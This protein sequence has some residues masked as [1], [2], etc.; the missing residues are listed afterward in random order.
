MATDSAWF[1]PLIRR[2]V[3]ESAEM[4]LRLLE[5]DLVDRLALVAERV[6]DSYRRGGKVLLFGNGG[7]ATDA[8]HLATEMCGRFLLER[9]A[10]P[11]LALADNGAALTAIGNDYSFADVFAR[12]I[13]AFG[14][15]GDVAIGISTSGMSDNVIR[16][17]DLARAKGLVT[18]ALTG[19]SGGRLADAAELVI[20]VPATETP[21][22]QEG[23]GLLGHV[24]CEL[25]ERALF[26][27]PASVPL[28]TVFLDRDGTINRKAPAGGYVTSVAEFELLPGTAEAIRL[29]NE[30]GVRVV[31]VTNQR[32]IALGRMSE[33]DLEEIHA[34]MHAELHA[35]GARI[36]GVYVCP[37][38][39]GTCACRKP[40]VGLFRRAARDFPGLRLE[41]CAV[42][43]DS[44]ADMEAGA[45]LGLTCVLVG[46]LGADA[47]GEPAGAGLGVHFRAPDALAAVR[48][49]IAPAAREAEGVTGITNDRERSSPL[50]GPASKAEWTAA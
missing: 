36:D 4:V 33:Q 35:A 1:A 30:L 15:A 14:A 34:R 50:R 5:A 26:A 39:H 37:H 3:A 48:W 8:Q 18:V 21:R 45:R 42:V 2:R 23:H 32:G 27:P 43:G 29:L 11:A 9:R 7:S 40:E 24:L 41:Q 22:I 17:V 49:L 12:Q 46:P 13:E 16:A 47:E 28:D 20:S 6:V 19:G 10:L 38:E 31:V 25:V 44:A